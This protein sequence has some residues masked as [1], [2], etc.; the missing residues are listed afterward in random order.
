MASAVKVKWDVAFSIAFLWLAVEPPI[1]TTTP[2]MT[3][4]PEN[5]DSLIATPRGNQQPAV[6][7]VPDGRPPPLLL[8]TAR[9]R[10][11]V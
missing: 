7:L 6:L 2:A 1:P 8:A 9:S 11:P 4:G 5:D 10:R 3:K